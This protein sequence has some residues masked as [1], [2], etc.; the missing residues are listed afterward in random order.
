MVLKSRTL[1]TRENFECGPIHLVQW[2][3]QGG[4]MECVQVWR[5]WPLEI[6]RSAGSEADVDSCDAQATG[7]WG[8]SLCRF[9]FPASGH[10]VLSPKR[11][12]GAVC[13]LEINRQSAK[14]N[15]N[16]THHIHFAT[17]A[18]TLGGES[19]VTKFPPHPTPPAASQNAPGW[20]VWS[21]EKAVVCTCSVL[22]NGCLSETKEMLV[23]PNLAVKNVLLNMLPKKAAK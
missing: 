17:N 12:I 10:P 13:S 11:S 3:P 2:K 8:A 14:N 21:W 20:I 22:S 19:R 4:I 6:S 9:S 15:N 1:G 5:L 16:T 18:S 7:V 23:L